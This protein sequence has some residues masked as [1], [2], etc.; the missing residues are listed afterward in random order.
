MGSSCA[1][2]ALRVM[3]DRGWKDLFFQDSYF[4]FKSA[5]F[6]FVQGIIHR[7]VHTDPDFMLEVVNLIESGR[8]P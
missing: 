4:A 1:P 5:L 6:E 2:L 8:V 7:D 3:G